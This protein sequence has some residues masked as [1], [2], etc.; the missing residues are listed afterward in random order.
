MEPSSDQ[1]H[2][3]VD[4]Q[5]TSRVACQDAI[6]QPP[7]KQIALDGVPPLSA[8]N[9]FDNSLMVIVEMTE[10]TCRGPGPRPAPPDSSSLEVC[11]VR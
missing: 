2:I 7:I 11:A 10:G 6:A 3:S 9:P 8:C 1:G 5:D 4:R